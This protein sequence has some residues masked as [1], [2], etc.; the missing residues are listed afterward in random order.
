MIYKEW[1]DYYN[2]IHKQWRNEAGKLHREDGPA[3]ICYHPNNIPMVEQFWF[4][5]CLHREDGPA[6]IEYSTSGAIIYHRY[7]IYGKKHRKDGPAVTWYNND[8]SIDFEIFFIRNKLLGNDDEGFWALWCCLTE[9]ER[10]HPNILKT[11]VRYS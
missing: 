1:T 3:Y 9:V 11:L 6:S 10:Q 7:Y 5:D 4:D 2:S 8:G